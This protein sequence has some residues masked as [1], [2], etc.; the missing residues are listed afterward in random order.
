M[1]T[2]H[3]M[4]NGADTNPGTTTAPFLT[5]NQA[6]QVAQAGDEVLVHQGIYREWVNPKFGGQSPTQMITYRVQPGEQVVIKGSE[7]IADWQLVEPGVWQATIQNVLFGQFNP[8]ATK[9]AG[10]WLEQPQG[11][12]A[13]A[14][15]YNGRALYEASDYGEMLAGNAPAAPVD[16]ITQKAVADPD[17]DF[18]SYRWFAQ[19][20]QTETKLF[21]N[22][23][24]LDP[25]QGLVE[26]NVRQFC[27]YPTQ[28]GLNYIR[29]SGFEMAQ[30]A[31]NWAP[32]T[33]TQEG[34]LGVNWA[35]GWVID[36]NDL[37][38]AKCSALS[39]GSTPMAQENQFSKRHDR[40]GYQYQ[41]ETL[42]AAY[43]AGW[44]K[45]HIGSHHL[46]HNYIHDCGQAGIIGFLGGAF[47]EIA[48]N[49]IA[50]IG[51]RC[52]FGGWEIAGLKLHGPIDTI[53]RHNFI[54][55]CT[56]GIWLDWQTQG[57]RLTQNVLT[58]NLRDLLSEVNHG[59]LLVDHNVFLSPVAIHEYAQG[60]AF[61]HNLITGSI[62]IQSVL[63]RTTPYH[64]P[65]STT[66]L[67]YACV[68][69][70]DDR[71]YNNIFASRKG[72]EPT[73]T[74][75]YNGSPKDMT[76]FI[77]A[78]TLRL[79]GDVELFETVRQ[80]AYINGNAYFK[81]TLPYA[82]E[83]LALQAVT[84]TLGLKVQRSATAIS[85]TLKVPAALV[86][87]KVPQQSTATLG[88][89]RLAGAA[90]DNPDGSPIVLNEDFFGE[91]TPGDQ[92]LAGPFAHLRV[93]DNELDL[94]DL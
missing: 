7:V 34:L 83:T 82:D 8:F 2:Y 86:A 78:V 69:G 53:I 65:H 38:D 31:T 80:P 60:G 66:I 54:E 77:Q 47:S 58:D 85:L 45:A 64:V 6:A 68:Y 73:G 42:F 84:K 14:V 25:N 55:H 48:D 36:H 67:G 32:P 61:V 10:D 26:V 74:Q 90:F 12:H 3:V 46:H 88:H 16:Y 23:H 28:K 93:G 72:H 50:N 21:I 70:G 22:C 39:L 4:K 91:K 41:I 19:V 30:A 43:Q 17:A 56:L 49:H 51:T 44:D 24:D 79:P 63:N 15:Y 20:A 37:H 94:F 92:R 62:A 89:V 35:K 13:G 1:T 52:E 75:M 5:I 33:A 59:P 27:F 87:F 57:T 9:L 18:R 71:Y 11:R 29:V 76:A 81:G 40:P